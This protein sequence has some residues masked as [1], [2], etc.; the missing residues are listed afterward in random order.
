MLLI[1]NMED[2]IEWNFRTLVDGWILYGLPVLLVIVAVTVLIR[3][4]S[5]C[6]RQVASLETVRTVRRIGL[7]H[8][9]WPC[10]L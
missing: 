8:C 2:A 6:R 9:A 5:A 1:P 3:V 7:I 4:A 10:R